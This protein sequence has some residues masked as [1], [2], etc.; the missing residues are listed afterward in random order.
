MANPISDYMVS[1]PYAPIDPKPHHQQHENYQIYNLFSVDLEVKTVA[2]NRD[3]P[4]PIETIDNVLFR[5]A[6]AVQ[7]VDTQLITF[8]FEQLIKRYP[9]R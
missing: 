5:S 2:T 3:I 9:G 7:A 1:D 6:L 8:D 4:Q